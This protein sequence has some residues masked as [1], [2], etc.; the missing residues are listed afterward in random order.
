[1]PT[2]VLRHISPPA[3]RGPCQQDTST[4]GKGVSDMANIL[5]PTVDIKVL[6]KGK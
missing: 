3:Y 1:M 2:G 5:R 4:A 6:T